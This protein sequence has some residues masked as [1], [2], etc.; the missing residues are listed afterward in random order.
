MD[1]PVAAIKPHESTIH[2][3]T[4]VDDYYWLR[5]DEREDPEILAY[6]EA[7]NDYAAN[8]LAPASDM[9][10]RLYEEI[11]G[12][13]KQNDE[14][15][16]YRKGDYWYYA[17]YEKG[18][19]LPIY[20]RRKGSEQGEEEILLDTN[21]LAEPFDFYE[22]ASLAVSDDGKLL[23]YA[24]DTVSRGEYVIRIKNLESGELYP[25]SIVN[26]S[27]DMAW[28]NDNETLVYVKEQEGT[29]IPYQAYRHALGSDTQDDELLYEEANNTFSLS[30]WKARSKDHII[31][32]AHH[33]LSTETQLLDST[34]PESTFEVFLPREED[35]EYALEIKGDEAYV[36]TNW[37]AENFR[38]MKASLKTSA[39]K[40]TWEEV[41]PNRGE[42]FLN[43]FTLFDDYLVVEE[44]DDGI[45]KLR[46]IPG[47]G[48]KEFFIESNESAYTAQLGTNPNTDTAVLRYSYSSLATPDSVFD[49]DMSSGDK[50]LRKQQEVV[51]D[52]DQS[53]YVTA[54]VHATAR[55]GTKIPV[56]LYYRKGLKPDGKNPLYVL[57]YGSYGISY[58][59]EFRSSRL[60]LVDRG[61]VFALAHIRGGQELGRQWY[62]NGKLLKKKNT[63]TD[64]IDVTEH[65]VEEG[66]GD[67]SKVV[68][69]GR[70]AGGLLMGAIVN[71]RPDLFTVITTEVPF[72]DVITTMLDE[73]IPLT[74]FEFDEWGNPK[75][76]EYYDYMLSYSP[77]DQVEAK[78]Y[79][80]MLVSTGLWDPAVQYWEP[81][82]WVAKLRVT[83][84]DDRLLLF[85]TNMD[86][87]HRGSSGRFE[88]MKDRAREFAFIFHVLDVET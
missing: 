34:N 67:P 26:A 9:R 86:A 40:S 17:R 64:F 24:E 73:S 70:S 1:H 19:E 53:A 27:G 55:D 65:L 66:W 48:G 44:R 23:A 22:V 41:I 20:A 37:D 69:T 78:D 61:F 18:K 82:K 3:H 60:S 31:L 21:V 4:R 6:L 7:E 8:K 28:M 72:V 77:Y 10:E 63:F 42:V 80:H 43:E 35:H 75:D 45:L 50:T 68:A 29:L 79:P 84:T 5:D 71:M 25:E 14:T 83:K 88:R 46:V 56:S 2:G 52:F 62:E 15:V 51:G 49:Y 16:P 33:T 13:I 30:L 47:D 87:G 39:D 32:Y 57:G 59:P 76:K 74:T 58:D 38:L 36:R 85:H 12:R 54:R 11:V 81:A